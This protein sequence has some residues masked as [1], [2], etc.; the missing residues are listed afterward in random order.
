MAIITLNSLL[1]RDKNEQT[2]LKPERKVV[3]IDEYRGV[4]MLPGRNRPS[5]MSVATWNSGPLSAA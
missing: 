4:V 1:R 2:I 3:S 5:I